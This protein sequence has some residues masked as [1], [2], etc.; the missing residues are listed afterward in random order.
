MSKMSGRDSKSELCE[1]GSVGARNDDSS[2]FSLESLKRVEQASAVATATKEDSGLIDLHALG[3]I[4]K[5]AGPRAS[6]PMGVTSVLAPPDLFPM[7]GPTWEPQL[8]APMIAVSDV[9][10]N[11]RPRRYFSPIW[12]GALTPVA[13]TVAFF[14]AMRSGAPTP[15]SVAATTPPT[16]APAA[17]ARAVAPVSLPEAPSVA[18]TSNAVTP[19]QIASKAESPKVAVTAK[20]ANAGKASRKAPAAPAAKPEPKPAVAVCDLGCQMQRAVAGH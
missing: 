8:S 10:P 19:G 12:I 9:P 13:I 20:P 4:E 5:N 2:L 1:M 16:E 15:A 17:T 3:A 18:P 14:V 11:F 6:A 7:S